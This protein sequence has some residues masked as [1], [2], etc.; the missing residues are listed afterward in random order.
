MIPERIRKEC[1]WTALALFG[2]ALLQ[3]LLGFVGWFLN[4]KAF[5]GLDWAFSGS[6][7]VY[8]GLAIAARWLCFPAALVAAGLY[9]GFLALQLAHSVAALKSGLIFKLPIVGLLLL[10]LWFELR[11]R[12]AT[13]PPP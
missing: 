4:R 11:R 9:A 13:P 3:M 7:L 2:V 10:A 12:R 6:G 1:D 5:G 8:L